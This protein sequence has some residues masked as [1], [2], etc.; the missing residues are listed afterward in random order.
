VQGDRNKEKNTLTFIT[1]FQNHNFIALVRAE[2]F[3]EGIQK[4]CEIMWLICSVGRV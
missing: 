3:L 4:R 1:D 2:T